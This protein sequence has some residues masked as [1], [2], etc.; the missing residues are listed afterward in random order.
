MV[1]ADFRVV[2]NTRRFGDPAFVQR[3]A[4]VRGEGGVIH[5]AEDFLH[6]RK[7]V[8]REVTRVGAGVGEDFVAFVERLRQLQ[9]PLGAEAEAPVG[10]ALQSS[11]IVKQG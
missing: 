6:H 11:Q 2:E 9:R 4:G 3:L 5:S 1:V 8:L 7:I 10:F